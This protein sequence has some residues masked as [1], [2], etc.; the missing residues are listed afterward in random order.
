M[1]GFQ[2]PGVYANIKSSG[3]KPIESMGSSTAGFIGQSNVGP[4]NE[5]VLVTSWAQYEKTFGAFA[6]STYLAHAIY[7]FFANGG[8]KCFVCNV[9]AQN[10]KQTPGDLTA[11]VMGEDKGPGMR[12]GLNVFNNIDEISLVCAPG[13]TSKEIQ[14]IVIDH[15]ERLGDR[16]AIL[17]S[18]ETLVTGLDQM[19]RAKASLNA[20]FYFPW[21]QVYDPIKKTNVIQPPSGFVAG[22]YSRVDSA[23]GIHKA[24]ANEALRGV[25]GLKYSLT[26][27]EQTLLN[28]RGI[29]LIRDFGDEGIKVY[30]ARTIADDSEWKYINVRRLFLNVRQTIQK[31]TEWA[32]FE[33]NNESLWGSIRRNI[34][35]YLK[36]LWKSEALVGATP[37]EAFYVICDK[38]NN[39]QESIDQGILNIDIGM[40]PVK[41][42]EFIN[43]NIQQ[44]LASEQ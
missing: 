6:D 33:P 18:E 26:R 40:A 23:R 20:S 21:V 30:G 5:A 39:T 24:P 9:G 28:P 7:G 37:E 2:A 38:T 12:T 36:T 27:E 10:E 32:V 19:Y 44:A 34:G 35:A 17:D 31:G 14:T 3:N 41:P 1:S 8:S 25:T 42:A 29:N 15:C 16:F 43:I 13:M 4:T 22:L 11:L